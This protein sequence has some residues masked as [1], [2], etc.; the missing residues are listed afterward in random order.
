[1]STGALSKEL[2]HCNSSDPA[3]SHVPSI[4]RDSPAADSMQVACRQHLQTKHK[5]Q[6]VCTTRIT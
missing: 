4:A 3:V 2:V 5:R 6:P 1:M